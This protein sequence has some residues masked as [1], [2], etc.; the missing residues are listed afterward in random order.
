[1]RTW[2]NGTGTPPDKARPRYTHLVPMHPGEGGPKTPFFLVAGMFGTPGRCP[3]SHSVAPRTSTTF[4]FP[5]CSS[6]ASSVAEI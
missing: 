6:A 2:L 4:T 5:F 3:A 1:M